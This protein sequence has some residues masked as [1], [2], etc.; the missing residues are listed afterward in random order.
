MSEEQPTPPHRETQGVLISV[1]APMYNEAENVALFIERVEAV[2]NGLAERFGA[3]Y[4]VICV[5]DGSS[6]ETLRLL[7]AERARNPAIKIISLSRNFGKETALSA[8]LDHATGEAVIP[9][10]AD[11][12]DPPEL[13]PA[14]IEKWREGY[15]LVYATRASRDGE[16]VVKRLTARWFYSI[17]NKLADVDIPANTGDF[18]LMDRRVME[19]IKSL[20]ERNR[21]MKGIFAWVGFRQTGVAYHRERRA[22][23][24]TKWRYWNLW[25]LAL[26]GITASSTLPLRIW[27]YL[28]AI[29][30]ILS[31]GYAAYLMIHTVAYGSEVPGFAPI[32]TAVLFLGGIQLLTLGIIGEYLGRMYMEVKRRPLYLIKDLQGID[33]RRPAPSPAGA[34]VGAGPPPSLGRGDGT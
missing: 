18:R 23:G 33:D 31:F 13:I 32:M 19:A 3:V 7:A 16:S 4:E 20:P 27:S 9:I 6:D 30:S 24:K 10:D 26:D 5:D 8:G 11:L 17:Y 14:L 34:A 2:A 15:H 29:V 12:Q 22:F 25:N 1:V 21:F 28:G